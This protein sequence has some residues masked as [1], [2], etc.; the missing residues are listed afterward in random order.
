MR[1]T[2]EADYALRISAYLAQADMPIGA[3]H[4]SEELGI[5]LSFTSKI[6]RK[7]LLAGLVQSTRGVGGGFSLAKEAKEVTLRQVI[8]AID[9][10]VAIRHCL[11]EGHSCSYQ[12]NKSR[13]RFHRVFEELNGIIRGR[14]ELFSI[15]D[16]VNAAIPIEELTERLYKF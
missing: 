14:L 16:M 7:L 10:A 12:P 4:L 11:D 2:Q 5:P 1:I 13:C 15:A 8:E 9:G 6:L 3:P